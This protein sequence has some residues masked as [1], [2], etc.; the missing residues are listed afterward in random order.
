MFRTI[1]S[2]SRRR[3]EEDGYNLDLTYIT[4][5]IIAMSFPGTGPI[6]TQYRNDYET[7]SAPHFF[8]SPILTMMQV[9]QFLDEK[10]KDN[11]F[12][13]NVSEKVYDRHRFGGRVAEYNWQD[14]HAPPFHLLF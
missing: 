3:Y 11:Y 7:V 10:H 2:R 4:P 8:A 12:V 9:R 14:H 13:F 1:V 6:E 5:S